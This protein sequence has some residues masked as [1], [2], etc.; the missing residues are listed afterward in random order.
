VDVTEEKENYISLHV[1]RRSDIMGD[2]DVIGPIFFSGAADGRKGS[3]IF[4]L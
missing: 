1:M 3:V 4:F 2:A